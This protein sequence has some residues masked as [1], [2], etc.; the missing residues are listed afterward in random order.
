MLIL[1]A[2]NVE[3]ARR[4]LDR[5][6]GDRHAVSYLVLGDGE[7]RRQL[8]SRADV[9][10][11]NHPFR[12]VIWIPA[13]E[14]F[15]GHPTLAWLAAETGP[16]VV[17]TLRFEVSSRLSETAAMDFSQVERAFAMALA[18]TRE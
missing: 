8:A 7:R 1:P 16:V 2:D 3:L 13:P 4:L 12:R 14:R 11:E 17:T 9:R 6:A 10:A 15:A 18:E 5:A